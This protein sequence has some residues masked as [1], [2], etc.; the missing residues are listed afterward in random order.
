MLRLALPNEP[1]LANVVEVS[2][3]C[4]LPTAPQSLAAKLPYSR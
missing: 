2:A 1:A 3:Y 4:S